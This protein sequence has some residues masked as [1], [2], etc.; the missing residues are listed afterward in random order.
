MLYDQ[1]LLPNLNR[2]MIQYDVDGLMHSRSCFPN[3]EIWFMFPYVF[4]E[5]Q[6]A[7]RG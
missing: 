6:S 4:H 5:F 7:N 1:M 3:H 2:E